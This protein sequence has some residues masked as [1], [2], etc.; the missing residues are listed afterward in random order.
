MMAAELTKQQRE[1]WQ[2]AIQEIRG[3]QRREQWTY[4]RKLRTE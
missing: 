2:K 1:D 3:A 4:H